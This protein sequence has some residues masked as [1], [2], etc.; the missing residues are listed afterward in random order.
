[1]WMKNISWLKIFPR[2]PI[3]N[4]VQ[5]GKILLQLWFSLNFIN[6]AAN[7]FIDCKY[8]SCSEESYVFDIHI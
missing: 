2:I 5:T 6:K 4:N 1:M 7:P 8:F 3:V